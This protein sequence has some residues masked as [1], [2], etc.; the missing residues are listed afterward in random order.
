MQAV[1]FFWRPRKDGV[2]C[3]L[4]AED[5]VLLVRH[6]YGRRSWDVPGGAVKRDEPPLE[7][8]RRE[9]REELGLGAA[10]WADIG[11]FRG[12]IDHRRD[13][14]H[15]F[16]AELAPPPALKIDH[17]ELDTAQW[18]ARSEL[19]ADLSPYVI[20]IVSRAPAIDARTP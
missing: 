12:R 17:G 1:W 13:T 7:A 5:R 2:K 10:D 11:Q 18:F 3:L 20:A 14:I 4:T 6:T 8:A 9:M 19:P 16:R 15:C